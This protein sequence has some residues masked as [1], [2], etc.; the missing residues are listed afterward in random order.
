MKASPLPASLIGG[1]LLRTRELGH[2]CHTEK[3][4]NVLMPGTVD[5]EER[6]CD[7]R[8]PRNGVGL[9]DA[10]IEGERGKAWP[11]TK[12][13]ISPSVVS[14]SQTIYARPTRTS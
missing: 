7:N 12:K 11:A 1:C 3:M 4:R 14:G 2:R 13:R 8:S 5:M 10:V 9:A 6:R